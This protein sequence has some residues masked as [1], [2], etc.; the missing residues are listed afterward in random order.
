MFTCRFSLS[1][2]SDDY[3]GIILGAIG[4]INTAAVA[5]RTGKLDTVYEGA[6][7]SVLDALFGCF[8]AAFKEGIHMTMSATLIGC[9]SADEDPQNNA[10][11]WKNAAFPVAAKATLYPLD[12]SLLPALRAEFAAMAA[13]A[14]LLLQDGGSCCILGGLAKDIFAFIEKACRELETSGSRWALETVFSVN[15]PTAE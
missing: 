11:L 15:S 6:C 3:I 2:M 8:T 13:Q 14:G 10:A 4:S 9:G 5:S 1:P 7:S 12:G